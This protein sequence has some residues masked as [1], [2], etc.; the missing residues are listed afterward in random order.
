MNAKTNNKQSGGSPSSSPDK[1]ESDKK[2]GK[3][4]MALGYC[5][6][7]SILLQ[8]QGRLGLSAQEMIVLLQLVEHWWKADGQVFPSKETIAERV[9]LSGKQVQRHIRALEGRG[10]L[11]RNARFRSGGGQLSNHY[12]LGGLVEKLKSLEP[13][14]TR[15]RKLATAAT[16]P[17]GV[18]AEIR[19]NLK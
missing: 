14:I 13:G 18:V 8:T 15:A 4:V 6:F 1:K 17:G 10:F 7:P 19:D 9:G 5:I 12:D 3:A 16:R 11:R 2:W